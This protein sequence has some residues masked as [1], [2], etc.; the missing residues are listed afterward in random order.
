M[1]DHRIPPSPCPD[2]G[3]MQDGAYAPDHEALPKPGDISV[4]ISCYG[5]SIFGDDMMRRLPTEAD[6]EEMPLDDLSRYQHALK[7]L[8]G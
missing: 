5:V 8:K 2:C 3:K 4:C 1:P 6:I 7:E